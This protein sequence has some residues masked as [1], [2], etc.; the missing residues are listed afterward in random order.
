MKE[1]DFKDGLRPGGRTSRLWLFKDGKVFPFLGS[2]IPGVCAVL[3]ERYTKNGKWSHSEFRLALG[4]TVFPLPLLA[5]LH[6]T[7]W[8]SFSSEAEAVS[9]LSQ[10]TGQ[11][12]CPES[13]RA[14]IAVHFPAAASRWAQLAETLK[15][16]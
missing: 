15:G 16:L 1:F 13:F 12:V 5:P 10:E 7:V 4:D 8:G 6:G 14:A 11:A 9:W 3:Q 2:A